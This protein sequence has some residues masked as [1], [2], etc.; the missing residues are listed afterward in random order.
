VA[1][2]L[3]I[4]ERD[5]TVHLTRVGGG[6]GR[7]LMNDYYGVRPRQA[8]V[9]REVWGAF[10]DKTNRQA[11]CDSGV[12]RVKGRGRSE[13]SQY[14]TLA[15]RRSHKPLNIHDLYRRKVPRWMGAMHSST[16]LL[17]GL[18]FVPGL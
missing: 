6:F 2:S 12:E 13:R 9:L 3:G 5:I 7:R 16:A 15:V 11:H 8:G 17:N 4:Q 14:A 1:K 18:R 10:A